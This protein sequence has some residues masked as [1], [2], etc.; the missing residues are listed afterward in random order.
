MNSLVTP[1]AAELVSYA[2][3]EQPDDELGAIGDRSPPG[4]SFGDKP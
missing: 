3:V 2:I 1:T 4:E